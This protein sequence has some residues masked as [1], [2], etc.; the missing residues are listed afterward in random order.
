MPEEIVMP[1]LSDTMEEGT[2]AQWLK[3]EG[4]AVHKGD[5]ILEIETDKANMELEAYSDGTIQKIL[6]GEGSTVA[7]GAVVGLLAKPGEALAPS[8]AAGAQGAATAAAASPTGSGRQ[9]APDDVAVVA[10]GTSGAVVSGNTSGTSGA[11]VSGDVMAMTPDADEM[12][13]REVATVQGLASTV[14]DTTSSGGAPSNGHGRVKASPLARNLARA[15]AIDLRAL[16]GQGSGPG[17]RIVKN[18]V[19]RYRAR[20][21]A[22]AVTAPPTPESAPAQ[23]A[24]QP[25]PRPAPTPAHPAAGPLAD[26]DEVRP[27]NRIQQVMARRLTESKSTVPHFY[28]T[29]EIDMAAAADLRK[30][31]QDTFGPEGKV[32]YNDLVVRACALTLRAMPGVNTSW[33]DGQFVAHGHVNVGIAVSLPDGL[34]VPVIRDADRKG[35]RE[36]SAESK[37]LAGKARDGK[38]APAD[39]DGGT[40]TVSNLGMYDVE[41]FQ[42]IINPPESAILAVSSIVEKPVVVDGAVVARPRMRVSLSVDHR[43]IPGVPAAEFLQGVKRLLQEPLRLGF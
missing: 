9:Q 37:T 30:S 22:A 2:I 39:M 17:G 19:E 31:I 25:A 10:S 28:V 1:R 43:V 13:S 34:V 24:P 14:I 16:D 38:L 21:G 8:P 41:E 35:L 40:F 36:I 12:P 33:R 29:S 11:V 7:V 5:A 3:R 42:A 20:N 15:Y 4:E 32:S 6:M 26:G 18:D 27:A 23:P